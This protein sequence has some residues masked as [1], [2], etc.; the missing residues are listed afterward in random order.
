MWKP[1]R[2][3]WIGNATAIRN[4]RHAC[5]ALEHRRREREDVEAFLE[6]WRDRVEGPHQMQR[7]LGA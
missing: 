7:R 6:A 1:P 2:L 3:G 4:A 5:F